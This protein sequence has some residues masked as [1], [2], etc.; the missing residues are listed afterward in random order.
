MKRFLTFVIL[1][2]MFGFGVLLVIGWPI[3]S[4]GTLVLPLLI[5]L[6]IP[7]MAL[8]ALIDFFT[9]SI[10]AWER[11]I[12]MAV[13]GFATTMVTLFIFAPALKSAHM[14]ILLFGLCGAIPAVVCSMLVNKNSRNVRTR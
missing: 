2:P 14:G 5:V 3:S 11:L 8:C 6:L 10:R 12:V 7:P 4:I 13:S 9:D 1:G